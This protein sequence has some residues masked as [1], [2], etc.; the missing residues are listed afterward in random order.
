MKERGFHKSAS[1][2]T[3]DYLCIPLCQNHHQGAEGL[4]QIGVQ[5]WEERF[6]RQA[7]HIDAIIARTGID[8]WTLAKDDQRKKPTKAGKPSKI[9]PRR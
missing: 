8:V 4:H 9:L 6:G 2:K 1:A 5:V 7:D 3:S